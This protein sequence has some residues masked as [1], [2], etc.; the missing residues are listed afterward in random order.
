M[1]VAPARQGQGIGGALIRAGLER[2]RANGERIAIVLGQ[3]QEMAI[4]IEHPGYGT[5]RTVGFPMKFA[6]GAC[7][8]RHPAPKLG[9]HG[10]ELR[11][12]A[13]RILAERRLAGDARRSAKA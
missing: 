11:Q 6:E 5:V 1:A 2:A 8:V 12:E 13:E 10:A 4:D 3:H 9:E 7:A